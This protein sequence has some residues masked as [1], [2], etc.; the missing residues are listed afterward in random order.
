MG[1]N[2]AANRG[3]LNVCVPDVDEVGIIKR[4]EDGLYMKTG[5]YGIRNK[6]S[7]K[8]YV[9]QTLMNFGDRRDSH[10]SLL[11]NDKHACAEMQAD[12]A[13]IGEDNFEFVV[14]CECD[15]YDIDDRESEYIA[16]YQER[17]LSYNKCSGGRI[18]Y[19][20]PPIPE[21]AKKIIGEK[22]RLHGLGRKASQDTRRKMSEAHKG[23]K[24]GPLSAERKQ[25]LSVMRSG[26]GGALAKLTESQVLEIR[27]LRRDEGLTYSE[28]GRRFG[29]TYQCIADIC[30]YKRWKYTA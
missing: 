6:I 3:N 18:G 7:G 14:L 22:N 12:F 25:Q 26:E 15:Y 24:R 13:D 11:R 10:F 27:R 30:N 16:F 19:T 21:H 29:V 2:G 9:G 28:I 23:K 8:V 17:G 20:G 5:I 1:V 4:R